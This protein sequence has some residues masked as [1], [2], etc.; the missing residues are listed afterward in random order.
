MN[1]IRPTAGASSMAACRVTGPLKS[2]CSIATSRPG[3]IPTSCSSWCQLPMMPSRPMTRKRSSSLA[4]CRS[5]LKSKEAG[6]NCG[7]LFG[8]AWCCSSCVCGSINFARGHLLE[9]S[10]G[11]LLDISKNPLRIFLTGCRRRS[12]HSATYPL[13]RARTARRLRWCLMPA[14]FQIRDEEYRDAFRHRGTRPEQAPAPRG[15]RA[16]CHGTC[17]T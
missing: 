9:Q 12:V 7:R 15:H 10:S 1:P 4:A 17:T 6:C 3:S 16:L 8:R 2:G 11:R 14:R 5:R 13:R